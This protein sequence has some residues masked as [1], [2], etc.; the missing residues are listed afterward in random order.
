MRRRPPSFHGIALHDAG[1]LLTARGECD[2]IGVELAV[3]NRRNDVAGFERAGERLIVLLQ[4][5]LAC[6][7]RHVPSTLAGMIQRKARQ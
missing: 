3:G 7:M 5:Q 1:V 6:P 2:P 4:R